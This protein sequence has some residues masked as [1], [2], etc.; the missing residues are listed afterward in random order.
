ME[1]GCSHFLGFRTV[2]IAT[3]R[4]TVDGYRFMALVWS[5]PS[6][7]PKAAIA[8]HPE[9]LAPSVAMFQVPIASCENAPMTPISTTGS[10]MPSDGIRKYQRRGGALRA[11]WSPV[12]GESMAG[13]QKR[14]TVETS[15]AHPRIA[16]PATVVIAG[17]HSTG[18]VWRGTWREK[19][20][21]R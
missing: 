3:S 11:G 10:M 8:P 4:S 9:M 1:S 18:A 20:R 15:Y 7:A 14:D 13:R 12:A 16:N 2:V 5:T 19:W 6:V 21:K 17:P